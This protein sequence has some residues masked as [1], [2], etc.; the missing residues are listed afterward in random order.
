LAVGDTQEVVFASL[1]SQGSTN[2]QSIEELRHD[3]LI[4]KTIVEMIPED[5]EVPDISYKVSYPGPNAAHIDLMVASQNAIAL[6]GVLR[7][8]NGDMLTVF[9]LY[10][11]GLHGDGAAGD[12]VFGGGWDT[13]RVIEGVDCS[14]LCT[15]TGSVQHEWP[16][17]HCIPLAGPVFDRVYKIES[18]HLNFDGIANPGENIRFSVEL[19]NQTPFAIGSWLVTP[20]LEGSGLALRVSVPSIIP[21]FQQ[22]HSRYDPANQS[23]YVTYDIPSSSVDGDVL[24]IPCIISDENYNIWRD[25]IRIDVKGYSIPPTDSLMI[26]IAGP[27]SGKLGWRVADR[28][29]LKDHTYRVTVNGQYDPQGYE[30]LKSLIYTDLTSQSV[31]LNGSTFPDRYAHD[32]PLIDGCKATQGTAEYSAALTVTY[33]PADNYWFR[34]QTPWEPAILNYGSAIGLYDLVPIKIVF[35]ENNTQRAYCYLRGGTPN[36]G[37][38][39]YYDVPM[40]VY[41][42]SDTNNPRQLNVAFVEQKGTATEDHTWMPDV[43]ST[44]REYLFIFKST[45]S[46]SP[47]QFYVQRRINSNSNEMDILYHCWLYCKTSTSRFQNGDYFLL[48]PTIPISY[49]D[50]FLVN[51]IGLVNEIHRPPLSEKISLAQNYPNPFGS[52]SMT[53]ALRT[54]LPVDIPARDHVTLKVYDML[55]RH[56]QTLFD[57][58][59]DAGHYDIPFTATSSMPAGS[60]V[61]VLTTSTHRLAVTMMFTR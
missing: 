9:P 13:I 21:A 4:M 40:R 38:T 22:D 42:I 19:D 6:S 51:P 27:A 33:N 53:P 52:V 7:K 44:N 47:D 3:A 15:Y 37:Y 54:I 17:G 31:L 34:E 28:S 5:V 20:S 36:Y 2:L 35:D 29:A 50:T 61:A 14:V 1:L 57:G 43:I 26:H 23:T 56:L 55:G 46:P 8:R 48:K 25:T 12:R 32:M 39:G 59:L 58:M 10:D 49:R 24:Q 11:D 16:A 30:S 41:D 60:Y 18:D 45:Y